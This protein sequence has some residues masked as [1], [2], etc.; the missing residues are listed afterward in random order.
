MPIPPKLGFEA[1]E[2]AIRKFLTKDVKGVATIPGQA[3][4]D[5]IRI[6]VDKYAKQISMSGKNV[7][8][9]TVKEVENA[10]DYGMALSKQR[11]KEEALKKFP[12]ETHKFFGRPLKDQDFKEIDKLYPPKTDVPDWTKGWTPK[13]HVNPE[14]IK[15]GFS[16]QMKLNSESQNKQM[17]KKF[18]QRENTEF[19]SLNR[20]QRKEVLDMFDTHMRPKKPDMASGGIARWGIVKVD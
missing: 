6:L 3:M 11:A 10:M 13:L 5:K 4:K 16:T 20:D 19:N 2:W 17:I 8:E 18:I 15:Q 12:P 9:V 7:N 14:R 1:I